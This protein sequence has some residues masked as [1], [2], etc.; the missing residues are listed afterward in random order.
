MKK[1]LFLAFFIGICAYFPSF[2]N[3]GD[4]SGVYIFPK[5]V[6]SYQRIDSAELKIDVAGLGSESSELSD[7]KDSTFGGAFSIG[8]DFAP[9]FGRG[10]RTELEYAIRSQSEGSYSNDYYYNGYL[11][12][13]SGSMKFD[14]QTIFLN[15]YFDFETGTPFTPYLGGGL[16]VAIID[17]K[18]NLKETFDGDVVFDESESNTEENFAFNFSAGLAYDMN[19]RF[20]LDLGYR[21]ADFGE[22]ETGNLGSDDFSIK[23]ESRVIAHEVLLGLRYMY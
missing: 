16:G 7:E 13:D 23:G 2:A 4:Y 19:D 22:G 14:I 11:V 1:F 21:Y 10:I 17:A 5:F 9:N 12:K 3:A 18:G 6:Y 8:Y 15:I 20:S